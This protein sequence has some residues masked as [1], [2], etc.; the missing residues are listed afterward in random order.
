MNDAPK[1]QVVI[2]R[3]PKKPV[4][5]VI[6][7]LFFGCIGMMYASVKAA[8]K[9]LLIY[10]LA[11]V[12]LIVI[13]AVSGSEEGAMGAFA[14]WW[15]INGILNIVSLVWAYKATKKYN[16]DLMAGRV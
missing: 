14:F 12:I 5:A 11:A 16:E 8:L 3:S 1:P 15:P 9:M 13:A 6:L 10:I 7:A 2:T 4:L